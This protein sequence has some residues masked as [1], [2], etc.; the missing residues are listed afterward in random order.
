MYK[1]LTIAY[2]T[3]CRESTPL[4]T[5]WEKENEK[6]PTIEDVA[7]TKLFSTLQPAFEIFC[8]NFPSPLPTP[9]LW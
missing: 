2:G 4:I 1:R 5:T 8:K 7:M 9:F 6:Y 3:L